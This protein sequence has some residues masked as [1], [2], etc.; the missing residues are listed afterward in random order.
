MRSRK[1]RP[2]GCR[3]PLAGI[4]MRTLCYGER[5]LMTEFILEQGRTQ[6]VHSHP[7]EQIQPDSAEH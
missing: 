7:C 2:E 3:A 4:R 6:P 5:T 1:H